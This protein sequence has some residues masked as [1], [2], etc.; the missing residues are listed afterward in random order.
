MRILQIHTEYL[1]AG[2]ERT[3][4]EAESDLLRAA[5]HEVVEWRNANPQAAHRQAVSLLMSPWNPSQ[6]RRIR[7]VAQANNPDIAHVHNTWY[8]TSPSVIPA[9]RKLGIPVVMTLHNFRLTCAN[10]LLQRDGAPCEL[11]VGTHP[12]RAVRY[13]CYRDSYIAS[14]FSA[15]TISV[16]RRLETWAG[17]VDRFIALSDFS[18]ERLVRGGVPRDKV[19]VKPNFV[20]DPGRRS[21]PPS[22]SSDVLFAGRLIDGKGIRTALEAWERAEPAG[23]RLLV[24]GDGP[25]GDELRARAWRSVEFLGWVDVERVRSMMLEARALLFPSEYYENMPMVLVEALAGGVPIIASDRGSMPAMVAPLGDGWL[26]PP[27]DV[28]AWATAIAALGDADRVDAAGAVARSLYDTV[29][30]EP[31]ALDNLMKAYTF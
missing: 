17:N 9:L 30:S 15:A 16:N 27:G 29:Y 19:I 11:C 25:L 28:T 14:G 20:P 13:R 10:S 31:V 3:V 26:A 8:A 21:A 23:L 1:Q 7:G 22:A 18:V 6:A 5:G 2:G 24:A 12:W 4:V